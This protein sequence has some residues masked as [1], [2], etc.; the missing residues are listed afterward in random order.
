M[1]TDRF[2]C[3]CADLFNL[4][5]N[6]FIVLRLLV[7]GAACRAFKTWREGVI[8]SG[9]SDGPSGGCNEGS[10]GSGSFQPAGHSPRSRQA[11]SKAS[12]HDFQQRISQT[13]ILAKAS[14]ATHGANAYEEEGAGTVQGPATEPMSDALNL[15]S[16]PGGIRDLKQHPAILIRGAGLNRIMLTSSSAPQERGILGANEINGFLL[17]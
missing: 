1:K 10:G 11:L 4:S 14:L 12:K 15:P 16:F 13:V 17:R 9:S 8:C 3:F 6:Y 5:P 7:S 2:L